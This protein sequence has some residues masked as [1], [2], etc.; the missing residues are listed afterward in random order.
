M[1][2]HEIYIGTNT[3][4]TKGDISASVMAIYK[5][6]KRALSTIRISLSY[7]TTNNEINKFLEKFDI[8]YNNLKD[9][10]QWKKLLL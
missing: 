7:I 5:D 8:E 4:C 6:K 9:F 1:E 2:V 3:A 10:R